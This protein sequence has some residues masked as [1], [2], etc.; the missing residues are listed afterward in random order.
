MGVEIP[1]TK[2]LPYAVRYIE[3]LRLCRA[4]LTAEQTGLNAD[5]CAV[6]DSNSFI[7]DTGLGSRLSPTQP[8]QFCD[9]TDLKTGTHR[10]EPKATLWHET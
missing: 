2:K 10:R 1:N 7:N 8:T 5:M 3:G 9:V 6:G 4:Y